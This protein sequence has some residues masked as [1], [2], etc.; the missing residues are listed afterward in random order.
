MCYAPPAHDSVEL[1]ERELPV[2]DRELPA[3]AVVLA[4]RELPANAAELPVKYD[5]TYY[6]EVR[7]MSKGKVVERGAAV[8]A[9][10]TDSDSKTWVDFIGTHV[11]LMFV[12]VLSKRYEELIPRYRDFCY[13]FMLCTMP[14][15]LDE[16]MLKGDHGALVV[17]TLDEERPIAEMAE[18]D[19][20]PKLVDGSRVY[21][22]L[23]QIILVLQ[24]SEGTFAINIWNS[25]TDVANFVTTRPSGH[26]DKFIAVLGRYD[27][28]LS[29]KTNGEAYKAIVTFVD[30][31]SNATAPNPMVT[32][33]YEG[34]RRVID[35]EHVSKPFHH[36]PW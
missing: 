5:K 9:V 20:K 36:A 8:L 16:L 18:E 25:P 3:D 29:G 17:K 14:D 13:H 12:K 21:D 7:Y 33:A 11:N 32:N 2:E 34:L 1:V 4:E 24:D 6:F 30:E 22:Y 23:E 15:K 27:H 31:A 28:R 26:D 19:K 35:P 10:V